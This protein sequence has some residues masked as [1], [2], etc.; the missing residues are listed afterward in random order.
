MPH[1][2]LLHPEPLPLWQASADLYL[3]RRHSNTHRQVWLSLCGV[4]WCAQGFVC[5]LQ[6]SVSPVLCK[7]WQLY[8]GVNCTIALISQASKVMLK[9]LQASLQQYVNHEPPDVQGGFR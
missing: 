1:P 3:C 6:E 9:I 7:F 4:F 8:G 5:A 2:G